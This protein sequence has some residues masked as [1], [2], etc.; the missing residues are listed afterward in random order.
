MLWQN[1]WTT[2]LIIILQKYYIL[3]YNNFIDVYFIMGISMN[4]FKLQM[5]SYTSHFADI[6]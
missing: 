6:L 4:I 1:F 2:L 5:Y 3:V